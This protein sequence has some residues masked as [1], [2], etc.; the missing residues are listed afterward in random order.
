MSQN[1]WYPA[2][3]NTAGAV[4]A[5]QG[6]PNTDANAWPVRIT[7]GT[8][9]ATV[10]VGGA[11]NVA[12]ASGLSNPLPVTDAAAEASLSSI[13]T[14]LSSQATAAKQD[15]GNASLASI[16]TKLTAPLSVTGP[17]TD[18][19]LRA[20]PVPVSISSGISNPLPVQDSA[21]E[22]SLASID[23]NVIVADTD[24]VTVIASA[25]PSG[26]AKE[27]K[28]APSD[29]VVNYDYR[30]ISYVGVTQKI[31]T[32]IYKTGGSGGST[33]ATQTFG[34]DGSDRLTSITTT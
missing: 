10:T 20:T 28:Q 34:Y 9:D 15:T 12:I 8:H 4:T 19:E 16:D 29:I 22:A 6:A 32:I 33:V 5:N 30:A 14:K 25:L 3:S 17:L 7:D 11:L 21:A 24:N 31:D 2:G 18:A 26:A 1:F 23:S 13:D 27:S